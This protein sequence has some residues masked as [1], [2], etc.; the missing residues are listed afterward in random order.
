VTIYSLHIWFALL[1]REFMKRSSHRH[2]VA[3]L[4]EICGLYQKEFADLIGCSRIYVQKIEQTPQHS[5]QRL[6]EKLAQR[7]FH[8]TGIS[9][10]WL[11]DGDPLAPPLSGRGEPYTRQTFERSQAE[12]IYFDRVA[13]WQFSNDFLDFAGRLRAILAR[14]NQRKTYYMVAYQVRKFID[15]LAEKHGE[16]KT[17]STNRLITIPAIESDIAEW[18]GLVKQAREVTW[19][20]KKRPSPKKRRR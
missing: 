19:P 2:P 14:A 6:S 5:G 1:R 16:D 4:R 17:K 8:E 10:T 13:D 12:K 11:L 7:I 15:S 9:L 18:K 20:K 3:I